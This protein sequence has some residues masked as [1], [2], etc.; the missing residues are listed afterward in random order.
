MS[1]SYGSSAGGEQEP[2]FG[3]RARESLQRA[4]GTLERLIKGLPGVRGYVDKEER[5]NTDY[6]LRQMIADEL[7]RS[8]STLYEVQN[9]L[10]NSGGLAHL[11]ALGR[12]I[13]KISNLTD[14]IRTASYGYA[15]L[16]DAVRI[17]EAQLDALHRFDMG[18]LNEVAKLEDAVTALREKMGDRANLG[19]LIDQ[20]T[21]AASELTMLFDRRERAVQSPDLLADRSFAPD[22]RLPEGVN[23]D[24]GSDPNQSLGAGAAMTSATAPHSTDVGDLSTGHSDA[25]PAAA[26]DPSI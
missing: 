12:A 26:G 13:T 2:D 24:A 25:P 14:R 11:D 21:N 19:S 17:E 5:R 10:L 23:V 3:T 16:F 7:E 6:R 22:V 4:Q 9:S 20:V 15:G 8:R 18:L 1:D